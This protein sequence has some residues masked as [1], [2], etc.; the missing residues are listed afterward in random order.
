MLLK[1]L[2]LEALVLSLLLQ[3]IYC[4]SFP[5]SASQILKRSHNGTW[6]FYFKATCAW[7]DWRVRNKN[8]RL[9]HSCSLKYT[10]AS[11]G[12]MRYW[13]ILVFRA[14]GIQQVMQMLS[15][16]QVPLGTASSCDQ[17]LHISTSHRLLE[18][19]QGTCTS[20]VAK[21]KKIQQWCDKLPFC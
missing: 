16:I 19:G 11:W 15:L 2:H 1:I 3:Q 6:Q 21:N 13:A 4:R 20:W 9:W 17:S 7:A 12:C 18:A 14:V 8:Q 5:A 10:L